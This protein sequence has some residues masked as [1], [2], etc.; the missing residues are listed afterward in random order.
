M[1]AQLV[2]LAAGAS[3]VTLERLRAL[4]GLREVVLPGG[5]SEVGHGWFARTQVSCVVIPGSVRRVGAYAFAGCRVLE[6]VE[7]D[8]NSTLEWVG[9]MAFSR[10]HLGRFEAPAG[11]RALGEGAFS[12]CERLASVVLNEGLEEVGAGSEGVL[13]VFEGSA[14]RKI[15]FPESLRVIR[16]RAFS[17]CKNLKNLEFPA[18]LEVLG[19]QALRQTG[20]RELFLGAGLKK[21]GFGVLEGCR[22]LETV[23]LAKGCGVDVRG[24][25]S[26]GVTIIHSAPLVVGSASLSAC[27]ALKDVSLP[28]GLLRVG[29]EWF[30]NSGVESVSVPESVLEIGRMTFSGCE[31]LR[32]VVFRGNS[33]LRKLGNDCFRDSGLEHFSVPGSVETIGERAFQG[34]AAL[35]EISFCK[36]CALKVVKLDAFHTSGLTS[37]V[38]PNSLR[39]LTQ[40]AFFGCKHLK[41]VELNEGLE[42]LGLEAGLQSDK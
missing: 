32:N 21:L 16:A 39:E 29:S 2:R 31:G 26:P 10:T 11:L 34:C 42:V 4:R 24:Y 6:G 12:F 9:E 38:A 23:Y 37:F 15:V 20:L 28:D 8:T 22:K 33:S 30:L 7:F 5:L 27:R 14:L 35:Q 40:G 18:G 36:G 13:G 1:D 19:A 17:G 41:R 25:V 3:E